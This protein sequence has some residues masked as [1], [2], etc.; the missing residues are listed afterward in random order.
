MPVDATIG[1]LDR[2]PCPHCGAW[3]R[4]LRGSGNGLAPGAIMTCSTCGGQVVVEAVTTFVRVTL[5][6]AE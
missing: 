6:R 3:I 1:D 2:A 5:R 4:D